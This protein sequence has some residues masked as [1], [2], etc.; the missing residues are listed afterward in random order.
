MQDKASAG[1]LTN[2]HRAT[3]VSFFRRATHTTIWVWFWDVAA[4]GA[5]VLCVVSVVVRLT[6]RDSRAGL[7]LFYYTLPP[8]VLT[9]LLISAGSVW[10]WK[11][12]CLAG[13]FCWVLGA[14][15]VLW[16][17]HSACF[18]HPTAHDPSCPR[19]AF[20]N[21]AHGVAGRDAIYRQIAE[22]NA[23]LIGLVEADRAF[24]SNDE[25][26]R[27]RFPEY[28]VSAGP[29][30]LVVLVRGIILKSDFVYLGNHGW[31]KTAIVNID[32]KQLDVL[33]VDLLSAPLTKRRGHFEE[34]SK[35]L[36]LAPKRPTLIMGDF[37]TPADSVFFEPLRR[38]YRNAFE[39]AG[40]GYYATWPIPL[41]VLALDQVWAS[42]AIEIRYCRLGWT[43][44]S[45]HRPIIAELQIP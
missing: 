4:A 43:W 31:C 42:S 10:L 14:A 19:V 38:Q 35:V 40:T 23:D 7:A 39:S 2:R 16:W 22:L 45:D 3:K 20:W 37:N 6:V 11:K 33:L 8:A 27:Q 25:V 9:P 1:H 21:V 36:N 5:V 18:Y 24:R 28:A 30:G 34:L 32:G 44:R 29:H 13:V 12:R 41:P 17:S 26:W 15:C